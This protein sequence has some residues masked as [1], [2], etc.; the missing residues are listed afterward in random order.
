MTRTRTRRWQLSKAALLLAVALGLFWWKARIDDTQHPRAR[1]AEVERSMNGVDNAPARVVEKSNPIDLPES[2]RGPA[3]VEGAAQ[4][5]RP[6]KPGSLRVNDSGSSSD[7][8]RQATEPVEDVGAAVGAEVG[9][10]F[11]VS[12]SVESQCRSNPSP[13]AGEC[14]NVR[15]LLEE[16]SRETRDQGWAPAVESTLR[17]HV[18][19]KLE[20]A[21]IRALECRS[22]LCAVEVAS[23][24]GALEI[25]RETEQRAYGIYDNSHFALGFETDPSSAITTITLTVF[26]RRVR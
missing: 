20:G 9:Q 23:P 24:A 3:K 7:A 11:P 12:E 26:E 25:L 6:D 8:R 13:G 16:M 22:S 4:R 10:P 18:M 5:T 19:Q 2:T 1:T 14:S 15:D 17:A 21:R